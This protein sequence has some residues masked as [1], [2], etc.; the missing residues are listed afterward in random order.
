MENEEWDA[1]P[2]GAYSRA[3]LRTYASYLGLDGDRIAEDYREAI[4]S[5]GADG[6]VRPEPPPPLAPPPRRRIPGAA[7][8]LGVCALLVALVVAI[9]LISGGGGGEGAADRGS[10]KKPGG[11][12]HK[13]GPTAAAQPGVALV[14]AASGEVW[15]CLLDDRGEPLIDGQILE[16]GAEAGPFRSEG[17]TAAF[18]NGEFELTING[19][20]A[21]TPPSASPVGYE[22]D[23][24][25]DLKPIEEGER[26]ECA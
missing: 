16:A 13:N 2:G 24:K 7:L 1:L 15:V 9:G 8:G 18:G 19:K 14:L 3:F 5:G 17:F 10:G 12:A 25:G 4:G 22:I 11:T 20:P 6:H 21:E 23:S 26:P